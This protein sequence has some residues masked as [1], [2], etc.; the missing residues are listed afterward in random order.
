MAA[1]PDRRSVVSSR[2]PVVSHIGAGCH[3]WR[4][5]TP[6]VVSGSRT[7]VSRRSARGEL[8]RN[9]P[10]G[11]PTPVRLE[12]GRGEWL[13]GAAG[14]P[15]R[16]AAGSRFSFRPG[17][18]VPVPSAYGGDHHAEAVW[19]FQLR[20]GIILRGRAVPGTSRGQSWKIA[21][22]LVPTHD[23]NVEPLV[24]GRRAD[25]AGPAGWPLCPSVVSAHVCRSCGVRSPSQASA[26]PSPRPLF[27]RGVGLE[28]GR[29]SDV[30]Q[31]PSR[32]A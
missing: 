12:P 16:R 15:T 20:P 6:A 8:E 28:N 5:G 10:P 13:P 21:G 7:V 4:V 17:P 3:P 18:G 29:F 32:N 14:V 22:Q 25:G 27:Q 19:S 26:P 24:G 11:V 2:E 1:S 23:S 31:S 30:R 9:S